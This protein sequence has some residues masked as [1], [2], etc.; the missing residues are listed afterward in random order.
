MHNLTDILKNTA[1]RATTGSIEKQI[2]QITFDSRQVQTDDVFV[3]IIGTQVDGHQYIDTAITKGARTIVCE[4]LPAD[5]SDKVTYLQVTNSAETMGQMAANFYGH[6][7]KELQLIGVTGTNGKTTT[8]TL[9]HELFTDL[10][11][12][13]GLLSTIE[14]KIGREVLPST[15]TTP[16][17]VAINAALAEMV[18][19][20]CSYAFMEVSSHAVHQRR[21]AGLAFAGGVFT[22]I[23]HD[24]L[25][26]HKTFKAYIEA[27]KQFFDDLPKTAFAL[28][29][30]DDRRG[31]VMLQN[32]RAK[33]YYYSLRR[34]AT[35]KVKIIENLLTGLLLEINSN[36]VFT[37]LIGEFNA[38][39]L[40]AIYAVA[41]L[42]EQDK[43]EIL[44]AIS[45]L[46]SAEGRFDYQ[47]HPERGIVG[48]VDYAHT[49]D[50]L[51]KVLGTIEKL[52]RGNTKVITV[53]GCGGDRDKAKRPQMT[54]VA[55]N[56]SD[57][58]IL[59]SDNPRTEDPDAIIA[60]MEAGIPVYAQQKTLSITNRRQAIRT[61]CRLAQAEDII[62]IAGKGHEK[63]QEIKGVKHD[64]DDKKVLRE[65][66]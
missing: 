7:S 54:K 48:I 41:T 33:R 6:P 27:K 12:K 26:Y 1:I 50:A 62:L 58:I 19:A 11:Y 51:E 14:N 55:C 53:V 23:T 15:H 31:E 9:L 16:D 59:T 18:A 5:F 37:R 57:Q 47:I 52:K 49:P 60:D 32:S 24:H 40:L 2:N 13:V 45:R 28:S 43:V 44:T 63:Y 61:A 38:Y 20:G 65:E 4:V 29:N 17:S 46:Q 56:Y 22:N 36:E 66:W 34:P 21:I 3:A 64:F 8:V 39:N 25:D 30:L 42:L 10:G 35:F